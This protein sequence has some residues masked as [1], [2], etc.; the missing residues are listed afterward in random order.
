VILDMNDVVRLVV[1]RPEDGLVAGAQGVVVAVFD[2]PD[3]AYE[4]EFVGEDGST[5]AIAT[6]RPEQVVRTDS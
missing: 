5:L 2:Q 6:L 1:D 3:R 4:V